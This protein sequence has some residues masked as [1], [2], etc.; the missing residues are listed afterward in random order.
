MYE[1]LE[2]IIDK[3]GDYIYRFNPTGVFSDDDVLIFSIPKEIVVFE[4][5]IKDGR[6]DTF[7][8]Y[9]TYDGENYIVNEGML[10]VIREL[11]KY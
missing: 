6:L 9:A 5:N 1:K 8:C 3:K 11:I 4:N 2:D 7:V 10:W